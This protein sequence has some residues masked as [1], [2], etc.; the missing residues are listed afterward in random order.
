MVAPAWLR[1]LGV[2]WVWSVSLV[3]PGLLGAQALPHAPAHSAGFPLPSK[4]HGYVRQ[5]ANPVVSPAHMVPYRDADDSSNT[6]VV[7]ISRLQPDATS[8]L[9]VETAHR[10]LQT[11]A[12]GYL[13]SLP[14][15]AT[16]GQYEIY[17]VAYSQVADTMIQHIAVPGYALS[18][19]V[20]HQGTVALRFVYWYAIQGWLVQIRATMPA[21]M[22][23]TSTL[24]LFVQDLAD[25]IVLQVLVPQHAPPA[26]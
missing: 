2:S 19:A 24:P 20:R 9:S 23:A 25:Y 3:L 11:Q 1:V 15:G 18:V 16:H 7:S 4:L 17:K 22:V 8:P 14:L 26:S 10:L 13:D 6:L 12:K 21:A 5:D